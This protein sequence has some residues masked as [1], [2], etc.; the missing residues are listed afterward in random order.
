MCR[1]LNRQGSIGMFGHVSI[2]EAGTSRVFISP[3]AG[4]DK[5]A[6][7]PEHVFL[8]D[9]DGTILQHPGGEVPLEW[10]IHTQIHADRPDAM[11]VVHLHARYATLL[12][13]A[14]RDLEPVFLHGSFLQSGVPTWDE[15]RLVLDMDQA[16]SLSRTLG[17]SVAVQM[18]GHGTVVVGD[19][20][21]SAFFACTFLEENAR[22]QVEAGAIGGAIRLSERDAIDCAKGTRNERLFRLLWEY[23]ARRT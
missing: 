8:F 18:R 17:G 11:C 13:I 7:L 2:R 3:G 20:P 19:T 16:A 12:G 1:M 21:E 22:N 15:P 6:V 23:H 4:S 9:L 5:G 14:G 10:R